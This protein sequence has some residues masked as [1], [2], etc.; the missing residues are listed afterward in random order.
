VTSASPAATNKAAIDDP[1]A[2]ARVKP[3]RPKALG[4]EAIQALM[5]TPVVAKTPHFALHRQA[6]APV[7]SDLSTDD[8][9]GK[10]ASVDKTARPGP[11]LA[12]MVPKRHAKRAVTRNLIKR[13]ARDSFARHAEAAVGAACL[14][15]LRRGFEPAQFPSAASP[16]LRAAARVEL[17]RL[18]ALAAGAQ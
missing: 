6:V 7:A 4:R 12:V 3:S 16:A 5:A 15:R 10:N 8:A 9:P 2:A 13:Q 18:W 14:I 1:A 17:E 11:G